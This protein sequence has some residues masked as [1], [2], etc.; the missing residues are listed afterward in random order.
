MLLEVNSLWV[1]DISAQPATEAL[2]NYFDYSFLT[3]VTS[4]EGS[5]AYYLL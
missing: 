5:H 2:L 3:I 1:S 4:T